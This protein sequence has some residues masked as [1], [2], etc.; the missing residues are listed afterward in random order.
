[1]SVT[2][3]GGSST[4]TVTVSGLAAIAHAVHLHMGCTGSPNAH[5]YTIGTIGSAGTAAI[6]VPSREL[7]A[8]VIVYPDASATGRPILCGATA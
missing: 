6:T 7:G 2:T 3:T 8:T 1:V 5:L 4:I